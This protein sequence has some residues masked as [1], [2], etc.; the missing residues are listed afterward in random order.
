[1]HHALAPG[2]VPVRGADECQERGTHETRQ[3]AQPVL[4]IRVVTRLRDKGSHGCA[5][6]IKDLLRENRNSNTS[7]RLLLADAP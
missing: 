2:V 5:C 7:H 6:V 4:L 1:M 3:P